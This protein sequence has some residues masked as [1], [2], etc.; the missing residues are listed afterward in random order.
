MFLH[1]T[2]T[3]LK[4]AQITIQTVLNAAAAHQFARFFGTALVTET[5]A[6]GTLE[7][8]VQ[9][10]DITGFK[11]ENL[12]VQALK[13]DNKLHSLSEN[14]QK[15]LI[16]DR[17]IDPHYILAA[18][19]LLIKAIDD[20]RQAIT[21]PILHGTQAAQPLTTGQQIAAERRKGELQHLRKLVANDIQDH[22]IA[23]IIDGLS[24]SIAAG[25]FQ[26]NIY[27]YYS[28]TPRARVTANLIK[29]TA[30][31]TSVP[32]FSRG[33]FYGGYRGRGAPF[34]GG[35]RPGRRTSNRG[36]NA[37]TYQA[38]TLYGGGYTGAAPSRGAYSGRGSQQP[39]SRGRQRGG[40]SGA[41]SY[42]GG[43]TGG[44]Q[45]TQPTYQTRPTQARPPNKL[46][47]RAQQPQHV[48]GVPDPKLGTRINWTDLLQVNKYCNNFQ[49]WGYCKVYEMDT[50]KCNFYKRCSNC[51]SQEH[52]R[53]Q[54][55]YL[56]TNENQEA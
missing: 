31:Q 52:G 44:Y 5:L 8:L 6:R 22:V 41:T 4:H 12:I 20:H 18:I 27:H 35:F 14:K 19:D 3:T 42:R 51:N 50:S 29:Q 9:K 54:C 39:P 32:T 24:V 15:A 36:R 21:A 43:Y 38:G 56:Q 45:G 37:N 2:I 17:K 25:W 7:K 48:P 13:K 10:D 55:P 47:N 33:R 11:F 49:I 26:G 40:Y 23:D 53:R 16:K 46:Y 30:A 1:T 28:L 34:R